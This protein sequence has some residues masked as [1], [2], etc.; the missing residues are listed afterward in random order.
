MFPCT[1]P[2]TITVLLFTPPWTSAFSPIVRIPS[3]EEISP[4]RFP[5]KTNSFTNLTEPL[6]STSFERLFL[7]GDISSI[8]GVGCVTVKGLAAAGVGGL[9]PDG[10]SS[11]GA[12]CPGLLGIN[13][14]NTLA[15]MKGTKSS[16]ND[17]SRHVCEF[18]RRIGPDFA[19]RRIVTRDRRER[20]GGLRR[21]P[22]EIGQKPR[23]LQHSGNRWDRK[24]PSILAARLPGQASKF[25]TL[26]SR[27]LSE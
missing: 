12:V 27:T 15:T 24:H 25:A 1:L 10:T 9:S 5:S 22:S 23:P 8:T 6:I 14:F 21:L 19:R 17:F 11:A 7:L 13:F 4:S 26:P 16:V 2:L 20:R 3:T 18:F